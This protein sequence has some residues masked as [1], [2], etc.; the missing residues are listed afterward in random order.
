[1]NQKSSIRVNEVFLSLQG[2]GLYAGEPT[3][4]VRF[5]GCNL[6]VGCSWCDTAYAQNSEKGAE[7]AVEKIKEEVRNLLPHFKSWVCITGGE[8]LYQPDGL[9][10]LIRGLKSWGYRVEIETNGTI[11]KPRWYTLADCWVADIKCPSSGVVS[12]EEWFNM[13]SKDQ[14]KLVVGDSKDL[15]FARDVINRNRARS[16]EVLVSPMIPVGDAITGGECSV[17]NRGWL[18]EVWNFCIEERVRFS[19]Q[20]HKI[21]F[22]NKKGV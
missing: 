18:Q 9:R 8:P 16:P 19:L 11:P 2:E 12:L 5:Q 17:V 6:L 21:C 3:V 7:M 13:R 22:G 4:F 14:I 20:I 10:E 15:E 1:M